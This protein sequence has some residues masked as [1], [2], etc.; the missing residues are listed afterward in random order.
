MTTADSATIT[1]RFHLAHGVEEVALHFDRASFALQEPAGKPPAD[2]ARLEFHQCPHCPLTP[3]ESPLC[4][5]AASLSG[6][7]E[8]F[9]DLRSFD[10]ATIEVV[11]ESRTVVARKPLQEGMA[12]LI[13][14]IGATSGCPHLAFF[15]PMAR[16]HLPFARDD[17]TL[18]RVFS[19]YVLGRYL[20]D[21]ALGA[22]LL[23]ELRAHTEAATEV[24]QGMADRVRAA[25]RR[26]VVVG[27]VII[28]DMF[29]RAVPFEIEEG[30]KE[31][32]AL[33]G[34]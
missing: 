29:A 30:L 27:A 34:M 6:F 22:T 17:E 12:S 5:F 13:G 15:R 3:E 33:Y 10:E 21:G 24:N 31:L 7:V 1:Y 2:W 20:S 14:L 26:D 11:E 4:P 16:F 28:L 8:H 32:R 23:E 25:F 18:F 9:A 19:M